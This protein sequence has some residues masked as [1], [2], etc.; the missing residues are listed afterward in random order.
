LN[1]C[2][3]NFPFPKKRNLIFIKYFL[4]KKSS[5]NHHITKEKKKKK[6]KYI[7]TLFLKP[8]YPTPPKNIPWKIKEIPPSYIDKELKLPM[9]PKK[10]TFEISPHPKKNSPLPIPLNIF[11]AKG[12]NY[13]ILPSSPKNN[14]FEK[15]KTIS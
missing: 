9:P 1:V 5:L 14:P 4:E 12:W 13:R 15:G 11:F 7:S 6:K 3:E 8:S 2:V 10:Q